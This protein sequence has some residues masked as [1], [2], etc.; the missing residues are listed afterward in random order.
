MNEAIKTAKDME[1]IE[2]INL[3]VVTSNESAKKLY[4]SL[5]FEVFGEE[6]RA[7]KIDNTYFDEEYRV[8]FL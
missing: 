6:K 8:L 3:T 2:Q 7:L 4:T 5:G 1:G